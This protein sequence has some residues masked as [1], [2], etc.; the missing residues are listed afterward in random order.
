LLSMISESLRTNR[1]IRLPL[2]VVERD[3]T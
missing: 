3:T 2:Q 1:R